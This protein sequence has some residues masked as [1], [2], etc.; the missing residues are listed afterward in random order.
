MTPRDKR[1]KAFLSHG[2]FPERGTG[3]PDA[4]AVA[5]LA[6][7]LSCV[8]CHYFHNGPSYHREPPR[9]FATTPEE[10]PS[11]HEKGQAP[12]SFHRI[13]RSFRHRLIDWRY[14]REAGG[15]TA[16]EVGLSPVSV[17]SHFC[18]GDPTSHSDGPRVV[19]KYRH[20]RERIKLL[21]LQ[22]VRELGL[23]S[24]PKRDTSRTI[25]PWPLRHRLLPPGPG[26]YP[27]SRFEGRFPHR[28]G[29][30]R[31]GFDFIPFSFPGKISPFQ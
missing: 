3:R 29:P 25:F 14:R 8:S 27:L 12:S 16:D 13:R 19:T 4:A 23:P 28:L 2:E 10:L 30:A 9:R 20:A 11:F 24:E 6:F 18:P 22:Q 26:S 1:S 7:S 15:D 17:V 5:E 21:R 31:V